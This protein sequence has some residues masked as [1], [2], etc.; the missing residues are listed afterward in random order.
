MTQGRR[1][2]RE[3]PPVL[4]A[5]EHH[6]IVMSGEDA[7]ITRRG[8]PDAG[9]IPAGHAERAKIESVIERLRAIRTG[10]KLGGLDWKKL[11]DEG[12]R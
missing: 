4:A 12:R 8:L 2:T 9:V 3:D 11:R 10:R 7:L 1:L 6:G 5:E